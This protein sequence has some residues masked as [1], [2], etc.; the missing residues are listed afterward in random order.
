MTVVSMPGV[1]DGIISPCF[2]MGPMNLDEKKITSLYS[3][4]F[5]WNAV[6]SSDKKVG[7]K[8]SMLEAPGTLP[9]QYI[10]M[11]HCTY[12]YY[13]H[14]T[15][16]LE[17]FLDCNLWLKVL[18]RKYVNYYPGQHW[19]SQVSSWD[20]RRP[21]T[22]SQVPQEMTCMSGVVMPSC[23]NQHTPSLWPS[24]SPLC[25]TYERG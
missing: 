23:C 17:W 10:F 21:W 3:Q 8:Y 20:Q 18:L 4:I 11:I 7:N 19:P 12:Y 24:K 25:K 5:E 16:A 22:E 1:W 9:P 6:F 15:L 2:N 14:I 13:I